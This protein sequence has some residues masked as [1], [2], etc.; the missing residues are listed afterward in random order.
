V[1]QTRGLSGE[2][3]HEPLLSA[4]DEKEKRYWTGHSVVSLSACRSTTFRPTI[5]RRLLDRYYG[6]K[7]CRCDA[8]PVS[9]VLETGIGCLWLSPRELWMQVLGLCTCSI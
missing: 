4:C 2:V 3:H 5:R 7:V 9:D 8:R 1:T 6:G